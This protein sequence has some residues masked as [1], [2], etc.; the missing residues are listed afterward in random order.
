[1]WTFWQFLAKE[2]IMNEDGKDVIYIFMPW[3]EVVGGQSMFKGWSGWYGD[4][5][6]P[7]DEAQ[8][9]NLILTVIENQGHNCTI[10]IFEFILN[11]F[12]GFKGWTKCY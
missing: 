2:I 1:M 8:E 10:P 3:Y 4:I 5:R 6:M 12:E 7:Q 9:N 11:W